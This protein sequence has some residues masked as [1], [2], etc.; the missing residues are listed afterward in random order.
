MKGFSSLLLHLFLLCTVLASCRQS[1]PAQY[2]QADVLPKLYPDYADVTVPVNIAPLCFEVF[3]QADAALTRF[4]AAGEELLCSGLKVRPDV[5]TWHR[6]LAVARGGEVS[7]EVFLKKDGRWTRMKPFAISVSPDSIDPW[8]CYRLIAPSYVS[9]EQLTINQRCLENFTEQVIAD[10]MLC[11]NESGGQCINCHSFQ[12]GNPDRMQLHARHAHGGTLIAYDGVLQKL[13][14]QHDSLLSA[15]VY[16]AW[17]PSMPLIAYSCNKTLQGFHTSDINKIE[18]FDAQSSLVL[19]DVQKH[20]VSTIERLPDEM[21]TFPTWS[22][23]GNSLYYCSA[24]FAYQSDS[25]DLEELSLRTKELHYAIFRRP[26]HPATRS[27]GPR[28]QVVPLPADG[29]SLAPDFSSTLPR[30]SPDGRWLLYTQGS[31]GSFHIWHRDADL[32]LSDLTTGHSRPLAE[33]NSPQAESYHAW[34]SNGRWIVFSSRRHDGVF[35]RPYFAHIDA[36][37]NA[38]KPFELPQADPDLHLQLLKS[39]NV[40]ELIRRP[41]TITPQQFAAKLKEQGTTITYQR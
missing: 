7:V 31:Y 8:L 33:C 32:W 39:Y 23:D 15:P 5:E 41:V 24:H 18:V 25:I 2:A 12:Q 27:F 14:M 13:L 16:P 10:N 1:I 40:P 20:E 6:L 36:D 30:I 26:F 29:D 37:G 3:N 21:A 4:S 34:S 11:S 28:E 38:S 22:P 17:H 19:Y 9:Y 35:T